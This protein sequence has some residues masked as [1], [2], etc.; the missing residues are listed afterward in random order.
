[1]IHRLKGVKVNDG[2][3]GKEP[4]KGRRKCQRIK[5]QDKKKSTT[6]HATECCSGCSRNP[7][8]ALQVSMTRRRERKSVEHRKSQVSWS[9]FFLMEDGNSLVCVEKRWVGMLFYV[10]TK[11]KKLHNGD[12]DNIFQ[13]VDRSD[14][15]PR[16]RIRWQTELHSE[17]RGLQ[18]P[19]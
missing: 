2:G 8:Q 12:G 6:R 16:D 19:V 1:M 9:T 4:M 10:F 14:W 13:Q 11:W 18:E 7:I 3:E 17:S 5:Q 15:I